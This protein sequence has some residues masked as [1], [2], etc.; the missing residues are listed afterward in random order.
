MATSSRRTR[1]RPRRHGAWAE[2]RRENP[3][4]SQFVSQHYPLEL[5][6]TCRTAG[7]QRFGQTLT[8]H[9]KADRPG[10]CSR[11]LIFAAD[12]TAGGGSWRF[13]LGH[14]SRPP[15]SSCFSTA[16]FS[17]S[18][19]AWTWCARAGEC[20]RFT[21]VESREN[22]HRPIATARTARSS[23]ASAP[24]VGTAGLT[25]PSSTVT[26]IC[27]REAGADD[28]SPRGTAAVVV[29]GAGR[30]RAWIP[31]AS[32]LRC[33]AI[34]R[35]RPRRREVEAGSECAAHDGPL[36]WPTRSVKARRAIPG[37]NQRAGRPGGKCRAVFEVLGGGNLPEETSGSAASN[38]PSG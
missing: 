24:A 17:G 35:T 15:P 3:A 28:I 27:W 32:R 12:A 26:A 18:A 6:F 9:W 33:A 16:R 20:T 1:L 7:L 10:G 25:T 14:G 38:W 22:P 8:N 4:G 2:R 13:Y 37:F 23:R 21:C 11:V 19:K 36:S 29:T 34:R 30:R 31:R 5:G